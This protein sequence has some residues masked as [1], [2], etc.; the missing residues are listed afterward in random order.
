MTPAPNCR[1]V[2]TELLRLYDWRNQ[3][4]KD[5]KEGRA[6][7]QKQRRDLLRYGRE[8]KAAWGAARLALATPD[9]AS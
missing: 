3:L 1:E 6:T 2:L 7:E 4:A 8:K 5:V 9:G